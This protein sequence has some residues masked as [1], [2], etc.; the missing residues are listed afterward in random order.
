MNL[1]E[2]IFFGQENIFLGG[3]GIGFGCV[4]LPENT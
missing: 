1:F 4:K 3:L 2:E